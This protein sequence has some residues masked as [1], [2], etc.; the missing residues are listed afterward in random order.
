M[1]LAH[2]ES[3]LKAIRN[4]SNFENERNTLVVEAMVRLSNADS[5]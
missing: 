2:G 4:R 5:A 3:S 1:I